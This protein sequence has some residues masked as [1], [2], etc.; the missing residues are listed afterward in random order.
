M[1]REKLPPGLPPPWM[2]EEI[3]KKERQKKER[4][5]P[6]PQIPLHDDPPREPPREEP[7]EIIIDP[8]KKDDG[9]YQM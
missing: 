3:K 2:I 1:G 5:R 8:K 9:W 7:Y 4:E 6:Q